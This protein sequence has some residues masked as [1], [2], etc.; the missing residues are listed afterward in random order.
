MVTRAHR[1]ASHS[2][3][4][5][6]SSGVKQLNL[7]PFI[8]LYEKKPLMNVTKV[9]MEVLPYRSLPCEVIFHDL[10]NLE[11]CPPQIRWVTTSYEMFKGGN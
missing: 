10:G 3:I 7:G 9:S 8:R 4:F 2:Q 11:L 1:F 5:Y 6:S